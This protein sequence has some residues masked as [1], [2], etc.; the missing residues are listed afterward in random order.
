MSPKLNGCRQ[1]RKDFSSR[2]QSKNLYSVLFLFSTG[3]YLVD[4]EDFFDETASVKFGPWCYDQP[5]KL[6]QEGETRIQPETRYSHALFR[7]SRSLPSCSHCI[8][9]LCIDFKVTKQR[10]FIDSKGVFTSV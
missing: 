7:H 4:G 10:N 6:F 1:R 8:M 9:F 5:H 3:L 2:C